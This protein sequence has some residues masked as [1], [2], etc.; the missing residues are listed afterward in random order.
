VNAALDRDKAALV[1]V[2]VA[3]R[4]G[5]QVLAVAPGHDAWSGEGFPLRVAP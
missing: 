2:V 3:M 5:P 4:D 1:I